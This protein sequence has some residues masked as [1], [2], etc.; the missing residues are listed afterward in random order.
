[1]KRFPPPLLLLFCSFL[2]GSCSSWTYKAMYPTLFDGRYDSE[3][4]Y[5]DYSTQLKELSETVK[6][7]TVMAHYKTYVFPLNDSV[8]I[9]NASLVLASGTLPV[10]SFEDQDVAGTG[11]IIFNKDGKIALLSCAHIV[12][13]PDTVVTRH[14]DPNNL[15]TPFI[16][17]ISLKIAQFAFLNEIGGDR[18]LGILAIDRSADLAILG[19]NVTPQQG[20]RIRVFTYPLGN[21]KELEWGSFVYLFGYPSGYRMITKGIVSPSTKSPPGSFIV[22]AVISPGASGSPALAIRDGLPNFE[23]VGIIKMIPAKTSYILK[24]SLPDNGVQYDPLEPYHGEILVER[25][26][27][28]SEGIALA[29]PAETIRSFL[30]GNQLLLAKRGYDLSPWIG[31]LTNGKK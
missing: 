4:L 3:F 10:P 24:P 31:P 2:L 14:A 28:I 20:A 19:Q 29:I 11:T 9:E 1:M 6:Q 16:R 25:K 21:A 12:D 17:S 5:R 13:F 26:T 18:S 15:P 8:R 22:D 23:L 7:M 27:E 30:E